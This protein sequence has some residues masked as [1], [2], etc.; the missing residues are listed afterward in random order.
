[1]VAF[2]PQIGLLH[3]RMDFMDWLFQT[4][5]LP[6]VSEMLWSHPEDITCYA[7]K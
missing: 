7:L 3:R 4:E 6:Q 2:E 1:M 5:K